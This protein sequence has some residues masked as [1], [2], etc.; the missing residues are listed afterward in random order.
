MNEYLKRFNA[1]DETM[2][3]APDPKRGPNKMHLANLV[4]LQERHKWLQKQ[5][6]QMETLYDSQMKVVEDLKGANEG[7]I[8]SNKELTMV[9]SALQKRNEDL[10]QMSMNLAYGLRRV[11]SPPQT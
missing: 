5:H 8:K 4:R 9:V 1:T 7:L 3:E 10:L 6:G 2:M 11:A